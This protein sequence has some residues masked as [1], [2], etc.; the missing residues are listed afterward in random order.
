MKGGGKTR[1]RV[2]QLVKSP[3]GDIFSD[4]EVLHV[5]TMTRGLICA[6]KL[7]DE[8]DPAT[9]PSAAFGNRS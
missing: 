5:F 8:V 4:S 3:E 2:H 7:G 9:V 6:M 1:V